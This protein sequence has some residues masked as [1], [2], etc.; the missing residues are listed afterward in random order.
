MKHNERGE[1]IE[2]MMKESSHD[3][4]NQS[5]MARLKDEDADD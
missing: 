4:L 2:K 5:H 3:W 1:K